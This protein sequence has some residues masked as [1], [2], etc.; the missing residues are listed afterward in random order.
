MDMRKMS[1]PKLNFRQKPLKMP[2]VV[3]KKK[4]NPITVKV[5]EP[6]EGESSYIQSVKESTKTFSLKRC[7]VFILLFFFFLLGVISL[8]SVGS[9]QERSHTL[10][11]VRCRVNNKVATCGD[12]THDSGTF[13]VEVSKECSTS[14]YDVGG[15]PFTVAMQPG[16]S[17]FKVPVGLNT[18]KSVPDSCRVHAFIDSRSIVIKPSFT[19]VT[20]EQHKYFTIK[21]DEDVLAYKVSSSLFSME[22]NGRWVAYTFDVPVGAK[23]L[24]VVGDGTDIIHVY[25]INGVFA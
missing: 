17:I 15:F 23:G 1:I 11:Q 14:V 4:L 3:V 12:G 8:Y 10:K 25:S 9:Y 21:S 7:R 16:S 5:E 22:K 13:I 19:W 18:V 20:T 24:S 2:A 6:K